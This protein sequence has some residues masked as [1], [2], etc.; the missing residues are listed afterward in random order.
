MLAY[1]AENT[2]LR[3]KHRKFNVWSLERKHS[4]TQHA[5]NLKRNL[6]NKNTTISL[7]VCTNKCHR[8]LVNV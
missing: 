8:A 3:P 6:K 5:G 2:L 7:Y 4:N 1:I